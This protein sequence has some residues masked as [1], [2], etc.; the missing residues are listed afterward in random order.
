MHLS[1]LTLAHVGPAPGRTNVRRA[2][3]AG[4][5]PAAARG[6]AVE[7]VCSSQAGAG[8]D[9]TPLGWQVEHTA[10]L[11]VMGSTSVGPPLCSAAS[12]PHC[13]ALPRAPGPSSLFL[14]GVTTVFREPGKKYPW[15]THRCGKAF[16]RHFC[17]R[18][19][20]QSNHLQASPALPFSPSAAAP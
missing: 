1:K 19:S 14:A 15:C 11:A 18:F 7:M 5:A 9:G 13:S 17:S 10:V 20:I 3:R 6:C 8:E 2:A 4:Q 12:H 16:F